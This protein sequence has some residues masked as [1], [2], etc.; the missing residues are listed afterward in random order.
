MTINKWEKA[1]TLSS[2]KVRPSR[3]QRDQARVILV[4]FEN[5]SSLTI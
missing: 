3:L 4:F 2:W 1:R 5:P